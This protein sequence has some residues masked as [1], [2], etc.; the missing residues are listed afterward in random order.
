M[1]PARVGRT[2]RMP[3]ISLAG[4]LGSTQGF[5][6]GRPGERAGPAILELPSLDWAAPQRRVLKVVPPP[7]PRR[8][9]SL[10]RERVPRSLEI[11]RRHL[12]EWRRGH[13]AWR[14]PRGHDRV[15][16]LLHVREHA[17]QVAR[18]Q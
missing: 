16:V 10:E 6:A 11:A 14:E 5:G 7:P 9:V 12:D 13:L 15:P 1:P 17:S 8:T 18:D 2:V 3:S 4:G